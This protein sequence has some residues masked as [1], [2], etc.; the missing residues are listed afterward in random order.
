[1]RS[2]AFVSI[3]LI[4]YGLTGCAATTDTKSS[5]SGPDV[6][7]A[8]GEPEAQRIVT[9]A[10][11]LQYEDLLVGDGALAEPGMEA[12]VHYHGRF[13]DGR[14]FDSS[15]QRGEPYPFRLGRGVVI[16]GW[17]EGIPGMRVGGKRRL[18]VP[19]ALGYGAVGYGDGVIPPNATLVFEVELVGLR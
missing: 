2:A 10:S 14:T 6:T 19:P 12:V 7:P 18:I 16:R 3:A 15:Y 4:L 8:A 17:D 1:M 13:P 5:S 9:T 11:G